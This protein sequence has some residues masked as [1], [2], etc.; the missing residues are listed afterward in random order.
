MTDVK[1]EVSSLIVTNP[2]FPMSFSFNALRSTSNNGGS[3]S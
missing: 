3:S 1:T 2:L